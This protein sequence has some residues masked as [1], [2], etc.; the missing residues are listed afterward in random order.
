VF[1][2]TMCFSI[3]ILNLAMET[4]IS[5]I[6]CIARFWNN[7]HNS[8]FHPHDQKMEKPNNW[9]ICWTKK[10]QKAWSIWC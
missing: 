5:N 3:W 1:F 4:W 6:V 2:K 10:N 8:R 7:F 9:T